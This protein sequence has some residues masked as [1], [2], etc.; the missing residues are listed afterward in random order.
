MFG[1]GSQSAHVE[2]LERLTHRVKALEERC[3]GLEDALETRNSESEKLRL[4]QVVLGRRY[5]DVQAQTQ[6]AV[7]TL[8]DRFE[9]LRAQLRKTGQT[10]PSAADVSGTSDDKHHS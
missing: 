6:K 4:D 7:A 9:A 10:D 8:F 1:F 5:D 3:R 2:A